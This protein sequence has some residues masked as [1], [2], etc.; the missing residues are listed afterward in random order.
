MINNKGNHSNIN[1]NWKNK[2]S[3]IN[4][5]IKINYNNKRNNIIL[6]KNNLYNLYKKNNYSYKNKYNFPTSNNYLRSF[7]NFDNR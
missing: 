2:N 3:F 5:W 6:L 7:P 4:N 1:I